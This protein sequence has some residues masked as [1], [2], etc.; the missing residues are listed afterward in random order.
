MAKKKKKG[1]LSYKSEEERLAWG[2]K[3]KAI[4]EAKRDGR[5]PAEPEVKEE[6]I[7]TKPDEVTVYIKN[8]I[9][10]NGVGYQGKVTVSRALAQELQYRSDMVD[11]RMAREH[12]STVH[13]DVHLGHLSG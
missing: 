1:W 3:M 12:D 9:N 11:Q 10:I 13:P 7:E 5:K 2:Q 8:A 6:V 4:R